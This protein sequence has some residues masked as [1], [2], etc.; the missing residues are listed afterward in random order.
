MIPLNI[1]VIPTIPARF[2]RSLSTSTESI[3]V[4]NICVDP[5]TAEMESPRP[6]N[7]H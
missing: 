5:N 6:F 2:I 4:Q 7:T 3:V 1:A